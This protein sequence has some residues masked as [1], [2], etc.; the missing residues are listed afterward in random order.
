MVAA[1]EAGKGLL[2]LLVGFGLLAFVDEDTQA[3]AEELVRTLH[4]NPARHLPRVFLDAVE[5]AADMRLWM[6]AALA[7]GYAT[8]R[9]AEAYGLWFGKRWAE[10]V[11]VVSGSLY[12]PLEI[13]ALSQRVSWLRAGTLLANV[14]I[15]VCI[16]VTL[17]RR[18]SGLEPRPPGTSELPSRG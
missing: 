18:R 4:L 10:W 14:A 9:L 13:Y 5:R 2:V 7:F 11:A 6:L 8:L 1:L 17:W 12:I 16:G 3:L 15:V